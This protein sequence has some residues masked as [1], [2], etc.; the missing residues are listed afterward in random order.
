MAYEGGVLKAEV[1]A[2][3]DELAAMPD[4][5]NPQALEVVLCQIGQ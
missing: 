2:P 3:E 1:S 4:G 5:D